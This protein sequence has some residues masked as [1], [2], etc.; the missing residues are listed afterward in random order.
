MLSGRFSFF[1]LNNLIN[2]VEIDLS[3]NA[4]LDVNV[5]IYGSVPRFQLKR[6][7][8]AGCDLDKDIIAKPKFLDTQYHLEDLDLSNSNLSGDIPNWLFTKGLINLDLGNNSLTGS[9]D[10]IWYPQTSLQSIDISM[11]HIVGQLPA[12]ISSMFP[13]L[14]SV[15][16]SHNKFSGKIPMSL[17]HINNMCY[18]D[19]SNNNFSGEM[20][21]CLFSDLKL[22]CTLRVSNNHLG[23]QILGGRNNLSGTYFYLDGN[24]FEG[25]LPRKLSGNNLSVMDLHD[26]NNLTGELDAS[27]WNLS[28]LGALDVT[29][30]HMTGEIHPQ[31]CALPSIQFL[32]LSNNQFTG[33]MMRSCNNTSLE[34]LDVSMNSLSG[35]VSWEHFNMSKLFIL[36]VR[37]NMLTGNLSWVHHFQS[38]KVLSLGHNEFHG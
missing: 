19:M 14:A 4:N 9:L 29:H 32:E 23:G 27:S 2:L 1:W 21:S 20:P 13:C 34:A 6:L 5:N 15:N 38:I 18:L 35:D 3:Q 33:S 30:N 17:C 8:L 10:P 24:K 12:N 37:N 36:D 16:V 25:A 7:L 31:I 28:H 26:N 22:L 11:N